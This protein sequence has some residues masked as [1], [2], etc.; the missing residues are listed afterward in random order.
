MTRRGAAVAVAGLFVVLLTAVASLLPVPYVRMSPGPTANTLGSVDGTA[1]IRIEG[2]ETYPTEGNLN[3]TTVSV[4]GGPGGS[5]DLVSAL[6]GWLDR[7]VAVVPEEQVFSPDQTAKQVEQRNAEEMTLSQDQATAAALRELDIPVTSTVVVQ[8]I[9]EG[10]PALG[11]LKAGDEIV[12]VDGTPVRTPQ[13]VREAIVAHEPGEQVDLTVLRADERVELTVGTEAAP[14]D[15]RAVVGFVPAR[16]FDFPFEIEISLDDV[17]GPSAGLMFALGIVDKL[18][19][20]ALTGGRFIAGTGT[21]DPAGQVGPIGG[22]QQK[23]VAARD[24]GASLFLVP[25]ANCSEA[26]AAAPDGLQ[27]VKVDTITTARSALEALEAGTGAA[28]SCAA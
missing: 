17:G 8:S 14:G 27:L 24:A 4:Q 16:S 20:G 9:A 10:S 23:V 25:A 12:E 5:V 26:V 19:P 18:T 22:I 6:A 15:G 28:P 1:L 13:Q 21:I 7:S 11:T 2:R 3:L